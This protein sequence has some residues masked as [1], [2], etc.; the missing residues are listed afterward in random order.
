MAVIN[1]SNDN[2]EPTSYF[3]RLFHVQTCN[4]SNNNG[5]EKFFAP[6]DVSTRSISCFISPCIVFR[7]DA[8][9]SRLLN[10]FS[11]SSTKCLCIGVNLPAHRRWTRTPRSC[12]L[13]GS[14]WSAWISGREYF[15]SSRS[16]QYPFCFVYYVFTMS[17]NPSC[18]LDGGTIFLTSVEVRF[19]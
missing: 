2:S 6:H 12:I 19:W 11:V 13:F 9:Y 5:S 8:V 10:R 14:M 15:P 1:I 7:I 18:R 16:S 4:K 17:I 3:H